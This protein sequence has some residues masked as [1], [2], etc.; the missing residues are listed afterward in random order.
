MRIEIITNDTFL[1]AVTS[2]TQILQKN[3]HKHYKK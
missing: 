1:K 2:I 3:P